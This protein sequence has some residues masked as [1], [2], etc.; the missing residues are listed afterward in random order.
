[1]FGKKDI[2]KE[3]QLK[4]RKGFFATIFEQ[5]L[6]KQADAVE[7]SGW[8]GLIIFV[9][10][11]GA[12]WTVKIDITVPADNVR[13]VAL[14]S[15]NGFVIEAEVSQQYAPSIKQGQ[16][17]KVG[18][19]SL[20]GEKFERAS[21]IGEITPKLDTLDLM[22]KVDPVTMDGAIL[23]TLSKEIKNITLRVV[24]QRQRLV[25][26]FIEKQS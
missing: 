2:K 13:L 12:L 11:L 14:P 17:V 22:I 19:V 6:K 21:A 10:L 23:Q 18:I 25:L 20:K 1:M 8:I 26:L 24:I 3:E 5:D 7:F 4:S 16:Q 15:E 9:F